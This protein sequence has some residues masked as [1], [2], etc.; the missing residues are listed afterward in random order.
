VFTVFLF[1]DYAM[2]FYKGTVVSLVPQP[3]SCKF[4]VIDQCF[5]AER[6]A[7]YVLDSVP[8]RLQI[9][10][11]I[12]DRD[13]ISAEQVGFL[14]STCYP[15]RNIRRHILCAPALCFGDLSDQAIPLTMSTRRRIP[16]LEPRRLNNTAHG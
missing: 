15:W 8:R 1:H 7:A 12:V 16:P 9:C 2:K 4:N 14:P 13:C 5:A 10:D 6:A 11:A 3:T